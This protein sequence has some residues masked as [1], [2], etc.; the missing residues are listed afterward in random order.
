MNRMTGTILLAVGV[1]L[2]YFAYSAYNSPASSISEAVTGQP[3]DNAIWF[4]LSGIIAVIAG[5]W[6]FTR[7]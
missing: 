6:G 1:V 7:K 4:L 3:A 5:G 2:L